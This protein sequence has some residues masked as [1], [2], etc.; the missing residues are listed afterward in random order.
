MFGRERMRERESRGMQELPLE[1][2]LAR[3]PVDRIACNGQVNRGEMHADLMR[4]TGLEPHVKQRMLRQQL[5]QLEVR[6]R[7][8]RPVRV[9]RLPEGIP[10]VASDRCFDSPATRTRLSDDESEVVTFQ[11]APPHHRL[12]S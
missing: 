12:Q 8:A 4:A 6:H 2:D 10:P 5:D 11:V 1:P 9:E 3:L 7:L